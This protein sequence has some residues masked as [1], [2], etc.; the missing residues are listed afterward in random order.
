M[1]R[2]ILSVVQAI[3]GSLD[4]QEEELREKLRKLSKL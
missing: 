3:R 2:E 4:G 1:F